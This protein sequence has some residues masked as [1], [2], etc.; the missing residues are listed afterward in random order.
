[1]RQMV[2]IPAAIAMIALAACSGPQGP[3]GPAGEAGPAGP[4]GPAGPQ[5]TTA[6]FNAIF[7]V[8]W[9]DFLEIEVK[10]EDPFGEVGRSPNHLSCGKHRN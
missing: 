7:E 1:M 6:G 5:T 9:A 4:V 8:G 3:Q 10:K 2:T